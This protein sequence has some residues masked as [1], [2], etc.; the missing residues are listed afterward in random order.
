MSLLP[1]LFALALAGT[2]GVGAATVRRAP[3]SAESTVAAAR[4][5]AARTSAAART[6]GLGAALGTAAT[7]APSG[8]LG[9]TVL[10]APVVYAVVHTAVLAVG[11][12]TWPRPAGDV[13]RARLARRGLWD[14]APRRLLVPAAVALAVV[15]VVLA[16][17][18]LLA[19]PDGRSLTYTVG[20][21]GAGTV[22][23]TGSPF[24]GWFYGRPAA[25]GLLVVVVLAVAALWLVATRPAVVT[26]DARIEEAL[27]R[28]SAHRV[29]QGALAALLLDAGGLLFVSGTAMP[30]IGPAWLDAVAA[31]LVTAGALTALSAPVVAFL[32]APRVPAGAPPLPVG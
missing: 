13:R 6:L 25:T 22:S 18:G 23:Q 17:G 27:R 21:G 20:D 30:D 14:S 29:L 2:L 24:P 9:V 10:L 26:R 12:L 11:E 15:T 28:A 5:H 16:V 19:G 7:G 1:L 8:D 3:D 32:P 31:G 4:R